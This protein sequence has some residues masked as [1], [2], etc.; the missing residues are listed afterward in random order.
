MYTY[1]LTVDAS[2]LDFNAD[3]YFVET[4]RIKEQM[5]KGTLPSDTNAYHHIVYVPE[6]MS[7]E[8]FNA[9]KEKALKGKTEYVLT[10]RKM[11]NEEKQEYANV[12]INVEIVRAGGNYDYSGG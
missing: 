2:K 4:A 12:Y 5:D 3:F 10:H 1:E 7:D 11:S 6:N 8:D 9:L